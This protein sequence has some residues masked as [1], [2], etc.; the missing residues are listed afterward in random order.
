MELPLSPGAGGT[1]TGRPKCRQMAVFSFTLCATPPPSAIPAARSK[2][3]YCLHCMYAR[4]LH[5]TFRLNCPLPPRRRPRHSPSKHPQNQATPATLARDSCRLPSLP[6]RHR[7]KWKK[8]INL[9]CSQ[10]PAVPCTQRRPLYSYHLGNPAG[11]TTA[12]EAAMSRQHMALVSGEPNT[13]SPLVHILTAFFFQGCAKNQS[14]TKR[15]PVFGNRRPLLS[16]DECPAQSRGLHVCR[17]LHGHSRG[18][19]NGSPCSA[20]RQWGYL[21]LRCC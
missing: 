7:A 21:H 4:A 2:H 19:H 15:F 14:F 10:E 6:I 8:A 17:P 5:A 16:S 3:P 20:D 11:K 9:R 12:K 1:C 13:C 18:V